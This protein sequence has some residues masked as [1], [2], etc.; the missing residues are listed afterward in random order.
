MRK[1]VEVLAKDELVFF[2]LLLNIAYLGGQ[3][4]Q[5]VLVVAV[6]RLQL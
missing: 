2:G 5:R 6:G 3:L 1:R 4:L